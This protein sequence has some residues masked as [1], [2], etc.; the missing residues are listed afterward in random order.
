MKGSVKQGEK[1]WYYVIDLPK[2]P[3]TGKRRQRLKR[4]FRT[5]GEAEAACAEEITRINKGLFVEETK[6]TLADYFK[7]YLEVHAEPNFKPTSYD[8][9][10]TIIEG[11]INPDIGHHVFQKI[12]PLIIKQYY[13]KLSKTYSSDYVRNIHGVMRRAF[14]VAYAELELIPANIMEKVK[15][16]KIQKKEMQ[17]WDESEW[18]KFLQ[19]SFDHVHYIF[20]ALAIRAG[21]RRG[22]V[23]G[24]RWKDIDF[25]KKVLTVQQTVNWTRNGL[26]F[27]PVP[28]TEGSNRKVEL[29]SLL[30]N[31]L[32]ERRKQVLENK[33]RLGKDFMDHDLVCCY[34]N[35]EPVKPKRITEG[36]EVLTRKAGIKKI[37]VHDLRHTHASFLLYLNINP[38]VAAERM[39][40]SVQMFNSRYSHLLPTMQKEAVNL[41]EER[42]ASL[43]KTVDK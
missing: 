14:R 36:M 4:G 23:L 27:Q 35:G 6:M 33:L 13:A 38:K 19:V 24:L 29:D 7:L 30:L 43:Q 25:N 18:T 31:E 28:K 22:E 8:T 40:M 12:T 37:R 11:R 34:E 15:T 39:G 3:V 42:L 17:F 9:E 10:K 21:M 2:D 1:S 5:E 32:K 41:I 16:P 20:F 26:I